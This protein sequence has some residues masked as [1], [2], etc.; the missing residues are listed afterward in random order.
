MQSP[1]PNCPAV[2]RLSHT[3]VFLA[4]VSSRTAVASLFFLLALLV[5]LYFVCTHPN[6]DNLFSI[7]GVPFSDAFVFASP[8]ITFAQGDGLGAVFRPGLSILLAL[9]YVWFGTSFQ[10]ITALHVLIGALT[11]ALIYLVGERVFT[12]AIAAAAAIFFAFD[13]SQLVQTPQC[14]T[15]PLGLMCFIAS[16]YC[17]LRVEGREKLKPAI[18]G[19]ALLALSNLTRPLTLFCAPFYAVYLVLWAWPQT[20]KLTRA[21]LPACAFCVGIVLLL[22]PWLIRQRLVHGVW[23]VSTNMGEALYG[24]TSPKYK[25]WKYTVRAEADRD[26]IEPT[27]GARYKYF[28]AESLKNIQRHPGFYAGQV[29]RSFW[30][31]LN[32]FGLAARL[33]KKAFAYRQWNGLIEAQVLFFLIL[34]ALLLVA[35]MRAWI[36][37]GLLASG[38]FGLIS[39]VLL[40][41][42]YF[43]PPY[44]GII[45]LVIGVA[46]GFWRCRRDGVALLGL[47]LVASGIGDA[48]FNNAILYRAVLMTDWIFSLFYLAAFYFGATLITNAVLRL[49]RKGQAISQPEAPAPSREP[50]VVTFENAMKT[51]FKGVTVVFAVFVLAGSIRLSALNFS[52]EQRHEVPLLR[53]SEGDQREIIA[54]LRNRIPFLQTS[55][56]DPETPS[57][58]FIKKSEARAASA[59]ASNRDKAGHTAGARPVADF[60]GRT[61]IAVWSETLS[62]FLYH[63]P[64]GTEFERRDRLFR[65]R[66]FDCFIL[67]TSF[68]WAVFPGKIPRSLRERQVVFVGW[69]EGEH[70]NG[71]R[72]GQVTQCIAII[73]VLEGNRGLDYEHA[74]TVKPRADIL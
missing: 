37:S 53:L 17:L 25:T 42:W 63:F 54:Q 12:K 32:S 45:I 70:P 48:I 38:L 57:L 10:V 51:G 9:F 73:P 11:T 59:R 29:S 47:S 46:T 64:V 24:A 30:D 67:R 20:K 5:R 13:P 39:A 35:A 66:P 18:L 56:P 2:T 72:F 27:A 26:G 61:Q 16:V 23:A 33:D 15:E 71:A 43:A 69:I 21:L 41:A 68:G 44:S 52:G 65:K 58:K 34:T 7:R 50:L 22:S 1:E 8:A 49:L 4:F 40:T 6:F 19:G 60:S 3:A 55:L 36:S 14:T 62:P 31:F 74:V 28:M